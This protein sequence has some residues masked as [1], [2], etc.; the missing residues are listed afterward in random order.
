M[1]MPKRHAV[2]VLVSIC[3]LLATHPASSADLFY[4]KGSSLHVIHDADEGK[5][6]S[7]TL[8]SAVSK[9]VADAG[10]VLYVK[11]SNH[12]ILIRNTREPRQEIV[13]RRVTDFQLKDGVIAY[14]RD[15][16]LYVGKLAKDTYQVPRLIADSQNVYSISIA[17]G[18][19]AFLKNQGTLYRVADLEQGKAERVIYPVGEVQASTAE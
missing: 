17:G 15:T 19:V 3:S 7:K 1:K 16:H 5:S 2:S 6:E 11:G 12:L 8:D 4:M 18:M 14:I 9:Y 13:D 10:A